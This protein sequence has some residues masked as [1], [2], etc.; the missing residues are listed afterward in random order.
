MSIKIYE[1]WR[2]PV[3]EGLFPILNL[4]DMAC[5]KTIEN[6]LK[7]TAIRMKITD[8]SRAR[9]ETAHF[10][11]RVTQ[12]ARMTLRRLAGDMNMIFFIRETNGYYLM[13][14]EDNRLD[15]R[16]VNKALAKYEYP[17]WDNSDMPEGMSEEDWKVRG[18]VWM[19][20]WQPGTPSVMFSVLPITDPFMDIC[21]ILCPDESGKPV[22]DDYWQVE[23][24]ETKGG[25]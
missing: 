7:E 3:S 12:E 4:L 9:Y 14:P 17:Y 23:K 24:D 2:W 22:S 21:N 25:K 5:K 13:I 16:F 10:L 15:F 20:D 18:E 19:R 8:N 11:A 6:E 1:G